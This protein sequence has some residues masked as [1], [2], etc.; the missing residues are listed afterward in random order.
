VAGDVP[1]TFDPPG[2]TVRVPAGTRVLEAARKAGVRMSATCGGRGTCGDCAVRVVEGETDPPSAF[3]AASLAGAPAAVRLACLMRANGPLTL[4]PLGLATG[5]EAVGGGGVPGGTTGAVDLG[6]T[7]VTARLMAEDGRTLGEASVAN[8]QRAFGGDVASRMSAAIGGDA[9][10]LQRLAWESVAEA[11]GAAGA[12][13]GALRRIVVAGNTVMTHLAAGADVSGLAVHPYVPSVTGIVRL[14]ASSLPAGQVL[15]GG[16]AVMLLPPIASFVGGDVTAGVLATALDEPDEGVRVLVDLGTNAEVVVSSDGRL[17]VSSAA[18]GPAFEAAGLSCGG[19]ALPGAVRRVRLA[20]GGTSLD[21]EVVG[22]GEALTVCGSGALSLV[23]TLLDA[24]HLDSTGLM[25]AEGSL[26]GRFHDRDGV[27]A[28]QVAGERGAESDVYLTQRDVRE[29]QLAKA[30]VA[31]AIHM[32]LEAAGASW[33]TVREVLVAG[34]FGTG[35][36]GPLLER[37]G[38]LPAS[39]SGLVTPVGDT[40]LTAATMVAIDRGEERRAEDVAA[41]ARGLDLAAD[42]SF[43]PAFI[44]ALAFPAPPR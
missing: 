24:G 29:L 42:P 27:L 15:L 6:T 41:S 33:E 22:G 35:V 16:S 11:L 17:T 1:V 44:D 38:V 19:P 39:A 26:A 40:A 5:Q 12:E 34:A 43:Q 14:D 2:V 20:S 3:E 37:L 7:T 4:R 10:A 8:G 9:G 30:A 36:D 28:L 32:T 25:L 31:T 23:A 13:A 21:L 18:A